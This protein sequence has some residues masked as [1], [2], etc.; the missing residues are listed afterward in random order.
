M[1]TVPLPASPSDD[2]PLSAPEMLALL[3]DQ[4]RSVESQ[5]GAFV[6]VIVAVWGI[7]WLVGFGAL[8]LIDGL[9]PAFSLPVPVGVT[10]FTVLLVGAIALSTVLGI[11]SGRGVRG[12]SA[13]AFTGATYGATW[14]VGSLA[15]GGLGQ[16][17]IA[18]GMSA[19]LAGLYYPAAFV[20]FSGIM[21][22]LSAVIWRAVPM[23][24]LG[25]W[26]LVI[27][28]AAPFFGA[29]THYL[30]LALAGGGG[31]LILAAA[32]FVHLVRLRR[33]VVRAVRHG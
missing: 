11:R 20:I 23:L 5:M 25:V 1:P 6:P 32:S 7:A 29:P 2:E 14:M 27:G 26:M 10:V 17:L 4:Q 3:A 19:E 12:S 30:V 33:R 18:N 13:E 8:W 22:M 21:Y 31:L 16:G 28:V 24:V 15:I 9:A